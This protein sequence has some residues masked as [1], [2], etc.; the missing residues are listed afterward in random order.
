MTVAVHSPVS[1]CPQVLKLQVHGHYGDIQNLNQYASDLKHA[2]PITAESLNPQ[3]QEINE[4]W[5]GLE[6]SLHQREVISTWQ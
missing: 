6:T 2:S 4:R 1:T 3:V 5:D